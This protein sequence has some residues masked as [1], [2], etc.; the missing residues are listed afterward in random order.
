MMLGC[1]RVFGDQ[2]ELTA[3][4]IMPARKSA[5]RINRRFITRRNH[6][7][8]AANGVLRSDVL[9]ADAAGEV[10]R[11]GALRNTCLQVPSAT[12]RSFSRGSFE[13]VG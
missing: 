13:V 4:A 3:H 7:P 2:V 5:P 9:A 8:A 1:L 6:L 10:G 12:V 11:P